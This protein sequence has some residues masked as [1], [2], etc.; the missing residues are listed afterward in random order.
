MLPLLILPAL[1]AEPMVLVGTLQGDPVR[2]EIVLKGKKVTG[3][4]QRGAAAAPA[5]LSGKAKGEDWSLQLGDT[6]L[7]GNFYGGKL[8][9]SVEMPDGNALPVTFGDG[10]DQAVVGAR[11]EVWKRANADKGAGPDIQISLPVVWVADPALQQKLD[12]ALAPEVLL[13][14][15]RAEVEADGWV[16]KVHF[17]KTYGKK[18]LL[19]LTVTIE[20]SGAYPD[21][22]EKHVVIDLKTG[23]TLGA[24]QWGD[25]AAFVQRA[26]RV[27]Q[28]RVR[29][30]R[31]DP[32]M[33][34][35]VT[36]AAFTA[37]NM[38]TYH[39]T[40]KGVVFTYDFGFPHAVLA[41]E[42]DGEVLLPWSNAH[43]ALVADS[44]LRR[45]IKER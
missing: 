7:V 22:I 42:P 33:A 19:S 43:E 28:S 17:D 1:A 41:A 9:G 29:K 3:T 40:D 10:T 4:W 14:Q 6:A 21:A 12:L 37:E 11:D 26:D 44:P 45:A 32:E 35:L 16:D 30:V 5:P 13:D 38:A 20:G 34:D 15:P 25:S 2:L 27:I 18:G 23:A 39:L 8:S 24:E 36:G 31:D